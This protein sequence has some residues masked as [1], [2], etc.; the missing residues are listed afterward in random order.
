MTKNKTKVALS[1]HCLPNDAL[2]SPFK[3]VPREQLNASKSLC[4]RTHVFQPTSAV[5]AGK[6]VTLQVYAWKM[7]GLVCVYSLLKLLV[8]QSQCHQ[9]DQT[10]DVSNLHDEGKL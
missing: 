8:V 10:L 7:Q 9:L 2:Y 4:W 1:A 6:R 5:A 3:K